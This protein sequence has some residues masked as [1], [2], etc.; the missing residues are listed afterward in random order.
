MALGIVLLDRDAAVSI[1][2]AQFVSRKE[3]NAE[4]WELAIIGDDL[5]LALL[6]KPLNRARVGLQRYFGSA[7]I[8]LAVPD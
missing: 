6:A 1:A 3:P 7:R 2:N 5:K 8:A 4:Q